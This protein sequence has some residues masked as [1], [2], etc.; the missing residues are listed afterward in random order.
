MI[1]SMLSIRRFI[2]FRNERAFLVR[3]INEL[4]RRKVEA[5]L[6]L[7]TNKEKL[8]SLES[9]S[10]FLYSENNHWEKELIKLEQA[11][12]DYYEQLRELTRKN[13]E[14]IDVT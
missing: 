11:I 8:Y 4:E 6:H 5:E 1:R 2:E 9:H 3:N 12:A 7:K 10:D 14:Y 13:R